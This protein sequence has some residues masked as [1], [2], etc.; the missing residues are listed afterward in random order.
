M[1]D[2]SVDERVDGGVRRQV[3]RDRSA[4]QRGEHRA[5][6]P[7]VQQD[8]TSGLLSTY[9]YRVASESPASGATSLI[10]AARYPSRVNTRTAAAI[11][12]GNR[13]RAVRLPDTDFQ[14]V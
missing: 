4:G 1:R 14:Y 6:R 5:Q 13:S 10:R 7:A 9:R 8:G 12:S 11:T 2:E 3:L